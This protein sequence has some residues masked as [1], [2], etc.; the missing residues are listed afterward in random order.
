MKKIEIYIK[1]IEMAMLFNNH[2]ARK[3][4]KFLQIIEKAKGQIQM[5]F[6]EIKANFKTDWK[7]IP[8]LEEIKSIFL[9]I[10]RL[11]KA[12]NA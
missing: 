12:Q 11:N 6:L 3:F 2:L 10:L 9:E 1:I 5:N 8:S 4:L 7:E